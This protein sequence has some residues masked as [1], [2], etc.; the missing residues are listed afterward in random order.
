VAAGAQRLP[1]SERPDSPVSGNSLLP[2]PGSGRSLLAAALVLA[3]AGL[4]GLALFRGAAPSQ[5]PQASA[6]SQARTTGGDPVSIPPLIPAERDSGRVAVPTPDPTPTGSVQSYATLVLD[7]VGPLHEAL[8]GRA[9]LRRPGDPPSQPLVVAELSAAAPTPIDL[10]GVGPFVLRLTGYPEGYMPPMEATG[11]VFIDQEHPEFDLHLEL[12]SGANRETVRLLS[13]ARVEGHV[14]DKAGRGIGDV[15]V[16]AHAQGSSRPKD[17]YGT[18]DSSGSY[19]ILC[20]PGTV[21][22][23]VHLQSDHPESSTARPLPRNLDLLP[24]TTQVVDF[25]LTDE[26]GRITGTIIDQDGHAVVGMYVLC[27]YRPD[28]SHLPE[29]QKALY[30]MRDYIQSARSDPQG[31]FAL[32]GLPAGHFAVSVGPEDYDPVGKGPL[33]MR[34]PIRTVEIW[35]REQVNLGQIDAWTSRPFRVSGRVELTGKWAERSDATT[36]ISLFAILQPGERRE[37]VREEPIRLYKVS[38]GLEF[39]WACETPEEEIY[40]ELRGPD[41]LRIQEPVW[42]VPYGNAQI[43]LRFPR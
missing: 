13:A 31:R 29:D 22:V 3:A 23:Q 42:P 12:R 17:Y 25:L 7:L 14:R 20:T 26:G 10:D 18:T 33:G 6:G 27:T 19:S 9:E 5:L 16:C 4:V 40:L 35:D 2:P 32:T 39:E 38:N 41:G 1:D 37:L 8:H 43:I 34:I 21:R 28:Q 24:N 30:T 11:Q 15:H 36:E